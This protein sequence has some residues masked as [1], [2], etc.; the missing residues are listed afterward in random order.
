MREERIKIVS[1]KIDSTITDIGKENAAA[2]PPGR[3]Y[4]YSMPVVYIGENGQEFR[5]LMT[6]LTKP[7]LKQEAE[8]AQQYINGGMMF[9]S[10][11]N[12]GD[13]FRTITFSIGARGITA[14]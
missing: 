9:Y 4:R 5:S 8:N 1:L 10:R 12:D 13:W 14:C 6:S 2:M 11:F 7:K 3:R